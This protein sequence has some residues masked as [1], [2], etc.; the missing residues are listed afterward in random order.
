MLSEIDEINFNDVNRILVCSGKVY[1]DLLEKRRQE[2]IEN[3]AIVRIE[4]LYPFP[5][6]A[7]EALLLNYLML[8][9]SVVSRR[10]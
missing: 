10:A 7:F 8:K 5:F 9:F 4:Q 3:V 6:E 1:Y 2:K